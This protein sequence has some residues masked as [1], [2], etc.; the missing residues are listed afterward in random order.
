[1]GPCTPA[2]RAQATRLNAALLRAR[3]G[4]DKLAVAALLGPPAH[5]ET[6]ALTNGHAI[7][8]FFYH[9]AETIC[10]TTARDEALLPLVFQD[11]RLLGYGQN[12]YH[13][14]IVPLLR[15]SL[16]NIHENQMFGASAVP[17]AAAQVPIMPGPALQ[18]RTPRYGRMMEEDLPTL[19]APTRRME[20][21]KAKNVGYDASQINQIGAGVPLR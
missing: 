8:V 10:R 7:E 18:A 20:A 17:S 13:S 5:A 14:F 21:G 1:M 19:T 3:L 2:D 6:F 15:T 11:E 16:S 9:T 12:Y 4:M